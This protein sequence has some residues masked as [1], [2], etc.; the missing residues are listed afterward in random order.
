MLHQEVR[1]G[2][3]FTTWSWTYSLQ[4][5]ALLVIYNWGESKEIACLLNLRNGPSKPLSNSSITFPPSDSPLSFADMFLCWF[6]QTLFVFQFQK[7][8]Q[9]P[10]RFF[11]VMNFSLLPDC[12]DKKFLAASST[13]HSTESSVFLMVSASTTTS[14]TFS[15]YMLW[16][17]CSSLQKV[18]FRNI[19][20]LFSCLASI[21][22]PCLKQLA[23]KYSF[24]Y[25]SP[26][27]RN[28]LQMSYIHNSATS[29]KSF[30]TDPCPVLSTKR[31]VL[32][33]GHY[34]IYLYKYALFWRYATC[35]R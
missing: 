6:A 25:W 13:W 27:A 21:L 32:A 26:S 14:V 4:S 34:W 10:T 33:L 30:V 8:V 28:T 16:W 29:Y 24:Q 1:S 23:Y 20:T 2:P 3:Q 15:F 19:E 18:G 7:I 9:I 17:T 22:P 31:F 12:F 5:I 35:Y 11:L